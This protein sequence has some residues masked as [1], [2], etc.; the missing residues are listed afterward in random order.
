M[1]DDH[2]FGQEIK[3]RIIKVKSVDELEQALTKTGKGTTIEI[4][5]GT[6]RLSKPLRPKSGVR[7]K[8][9]GVGKTTITNDSK[10]VP[11][12]KSLPDPEVKLKGIDKEAYLIQLKDNS[13]STKISDM[14]L[15]GIEMH[16]AIFGFRPKSLH[17][18]DIKFK[19]FCWASIR[20]LGMIE[21]KII[22]CEFIDAGGRWKKGGIVP[23][24]GGIAGGAMF[25]TWVKDSEIAH[26]RI[27]RVDEAVHRR[28]FGIKG[29][30]GRGCRIHHNTIEANFAIEFPFEGDAD[31][32]IDHNVLKGAISIP[33]H[34]GG[35]VPESG[36]TFH[37]HHNYFTTSY[38]IEFVRNGVEIDHN[39]FDFDL[40]KDGGNLISGFGKKEAPGPA[41]FHNNLVSN[42]GRG[43]MWI[44]G[45][46]DE[47]EIRNN[48]IITRK[49]ATPRSE[50]LFGFNKSSDFSK[51]T[52]HSNIIE[53]QGL[54]RPLFRNA[55]SYSANVFNNRFVNLSDSK[56]FPKPKQNAK[57]GLEKPLKF[58]C[59]VHDEWSVDG[60]KV[61]NGK[62]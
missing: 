45:Q 59:G 4:A 40:E 60:W 13:D 39:L 11:S 8:G 10:W 46:Y 12:K 5:E 41:F 9:A 24:K 15:T 32:E 35:K 48:H 20:T 51:T 37:I 52:I 42:P 25:L 50:G 28:H 47:I 31:M 19:D 43:V 49:T 30:Q 33:K 27:R 14:T 54:S 56:K 23:E 21:S 6:Y 29:R 62:K 61:A 36:R 17:L 53:C 3:N 1:I 18:H 58:N 38:A 22:D 16:G 44:R 57:P 34:A 2:A 55:E 7:L 26:N